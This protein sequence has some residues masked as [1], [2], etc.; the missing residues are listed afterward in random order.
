MAKRPNRRAS[1]VEPAS[2]TLALAE[3]LMTAVG[4]GTG[5]RKFDEPFNDPNGILEPNARVHVLDSSG[6]KFLV[7]VTRQS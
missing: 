3:H 4:E 1:T 6:R 2:A 5:F 7:L